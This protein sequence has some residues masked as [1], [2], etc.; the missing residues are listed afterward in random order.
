MNEPAAFEPICLHNDVRIFHDISAAF[1]WASRYAIG[2]GI[3]Y[4]GQV[5]IDWDWVPSL[6]R[7]ESNRQQD[8]Q[9]DTMRFI[10]SFLREFHQYSTLNEPQLLAIAQHYGFQT[11]LLDFTFNPKVAAFFA[12]PG[13]KCQYR[14][15]ELAFV[16]L[17][18]HSEMQNPFEPLGLSKAEAKGTLSKDSMY[19]GECEAIHVPGVPRIE[20]QEAVFIHGGDP[21]ALRTNFLDRYGFLHRA[22]KLFIDP[23]GPI[24]FEYLF[25]EDDPIYEF[26]VRYDPSKSMRKLYSYGRTHTQTTMS[27]SV[28]KKRMSTLRRLIGTIKM[29]KTAGAEQ[30]EEYPGRDEI[31]STLAAPGSRH[32]RGGK[33]TQTCC[34]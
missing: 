15:G 29:T 6:M 16:S 13:G 14:Y 2:G 28:K 12:S 8:A 1:H 18:E 19:V 11:K 21:T 3:A 34:G 22:E 24:C 23:K 7:L 26:V 27:G 9:A 17:R 4:R 30:A 25:P 10:E 33:S 5:N 20:R 31:A 32:K